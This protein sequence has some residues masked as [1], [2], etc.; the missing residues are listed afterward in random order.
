MIST[1]LA[2]ANCL[3][4]CLLAYLLEYFDP[5][6]ITICMHVDF[7]PWKKGSKPHLI[8]QRKLKRQDFLLAQM[9]GCSLNHLKNDD[10][11]CH[12]HI[13]GPCYLINENIFNS[14]H[15]GSREVTKTVLH[16]FCS[17]D[18]SVGYRDLDRRSFLTSESDSEHHCYYL[19][20]WTGQNH[21]FFNFWNSLPETCSII[22]N[23]E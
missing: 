15:V 16:D 13:L 17:L 22:Q 2:E 3:L 5:Q 9:L 12:S 20:G 6:L 14:P 18:C 4:I 1:A 7:L 23:T 8:L 19:D 11:H 10:P 21:Y